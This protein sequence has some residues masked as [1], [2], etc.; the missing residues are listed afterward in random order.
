MFSQRFNIFFTWRWK[1]GSWS[2]SL[3]RLDNA[4]WLPEHVYNSWQLENDMRLVAVRIRVKV[5]ERLG[6]KNLDWLK[7]TSEAPPK[8]FSWEST[9]ARACREVA[10]RFTGVATEDPHLGRGE[11]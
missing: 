2:Y 1:P 5:C 11:L 8:R 10:P 3:E 4:H 7:E 9:G 6:R